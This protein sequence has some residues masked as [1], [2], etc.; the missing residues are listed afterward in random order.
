MNIN[1]VQARENKKKPKK[2]NLQDEK[3][4]KPEYTGME[5]LQGD[6]LQFGASPT[7]PMY[8]PLIYPEGFP[9]NP[10]QFTPSFTVDMPVAQMSDQ[11]R[12]P[13]GV[14]SVQEIDP[15]HW[16][17]P[18]APEV[19]NPS[20]KTVTPVDGSTTTDVIVEQDETDKHEDTL[21]E[22]TDDDHQSRK[23]PLYM[24]Q[25][26]LE[27]A[28]KPNPLLS[29]GEL[30]PEA[31][32]TFSSTNNQQPLLSTS[33]KDKE[34]HTERIAGDPEDEQFIAQLLANEEDLIQSFVQQQRNEMEMEELEERKILNEEIEVESEDEHNGISEETGHEARG[35]NAIHSSVCF[36]L[37]L[38]LLMLF[39]FLI[40][41]FYMQSISGDLLFAV[42]SIAL[43]QLIGVGNAESIH[44]RVITAAESFWTKSQQAIRLTTDFFTTARPVDDARARLR[45]VAMINREV[46]PF[47]RKA[48]LRR[49]L[50]AF[51]QKRKPQKLRP[52]YE[53]R[54]ENSKGEEIGG[55]LPIGASTTDQILRIHTPFKIEWTR[56]KQDCQRAACY[57]D[58]PNRKH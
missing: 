44:R 27:N 53:A 43:L 40:P 56:I 55:D 35:A 32:P 41:A 16:K 33:Q 57:T 47:R 54:W 9:Y 3:K 29:Q 11:L 19:L 24:E 46:E 4:P 8:Y 37:A 48:E 1:V 45:E 15:Q 21:V 39:C 38:M 7:M 12:L 2:N 14:T 49:V 6:Q 22:D 52:G 34:V 13:P 31:H 17:T 10:Y 18:L 50:N 30:D 42:I 20:A 28:A 25:E 5:Y 23:I 36:I 26:V 58:C 51:A